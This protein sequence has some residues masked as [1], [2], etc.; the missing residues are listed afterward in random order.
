MAGICW[1]VG[2]THLARHLHEVGGSNTHDPLSSSF[3][4]VLPL[5]WFA[6]QQR[7][8]NDFVSCQGILPGLGIPQ[9]RYVELVQCAVDDPHRGDP[10]ACR[11]DGIFLEGEL[12]EL[13]DALPAALAESVEELEGFGEVH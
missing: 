8:T 5:A 10:L 3:L 12:A 11:L 2:S 6:A 1:S 7:L 13:P 4:T 9:G